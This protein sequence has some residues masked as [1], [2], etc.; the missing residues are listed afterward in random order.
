MPKL[1]RVLQGLSGE[2]FCDGLY[3]NF[4]HQVDGLLRGVASG[5]DLYAGDLLKEDLMGVDDRRFSV[6]ES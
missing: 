3:R 5:L 1:R 2:T 4:C 6:R